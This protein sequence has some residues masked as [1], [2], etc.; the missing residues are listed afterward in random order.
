[1]DYDNYDGHRH[2]VTLIENTPLHQWFKDSLEDEK[3]KILVNSYHRQEEFAE[4]VIA[5][6]KKLN[7]LTK[8]TKSLNLN[9]EME[10]MRKIIIRSFSIARNIYEHGRNSSKESELEPGVEFL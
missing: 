7:G 2:L 4:A 6:G 3:M 8:V 1:M 10:N 9:Q 5:Y